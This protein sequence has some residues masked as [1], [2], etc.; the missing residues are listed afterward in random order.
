VHGTGDES[1][2]FA[3]AER[4]KAASSRDAQLLPVENARHTFGAVHPWGSTT[5]ELAL[6]FDSSLAWLT[7]HLGTQAG[8]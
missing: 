1:V 2:P 6:V 3:E 4:L 7:A 5:P 8:G